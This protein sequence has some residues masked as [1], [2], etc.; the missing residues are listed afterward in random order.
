[1]RSRVL[2]REAAAG[3]SW[4]CM[5]MTWSELSPFC[6]GRVGLGAERNGC[7][8]AEHRRVGVSKAAPNSSHHE[9][10][11][12]KLRKGLASRD[13][14]RSPPD[15][16]PNLSNPRAYNNDPMIK[17]PA[18]RAPPYST[19]IATHESR[20]S[21]FLRRSSLPPRIGLPILP[22]AFARLNRVLG[23]RCSPLRSIGPN[24]SPNLPVPR[25]PPSRNEGRKSDAGRTR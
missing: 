6:D 23:P 10:V 9:S 4:T 13:R 12:S 8:V 18:R 19:T 1:M 5:R 22:I 17:K 14:R 11:T 15:R 7:D 2:A 24:V 25:P 21:F 20:L 3:P 16:S